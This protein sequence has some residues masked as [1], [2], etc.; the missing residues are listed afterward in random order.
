MNKLLVYSGLDISITCLNSCGLNSVEMCL[1]EL[2]VL[3]H[4][5]LHVTHRLGGDN[6]RLYSEN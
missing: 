3:L 4:Y 1:K 6:P 2:F 5:E